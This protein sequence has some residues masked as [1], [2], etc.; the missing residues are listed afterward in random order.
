MWQR[1]VRLIERVRY[2]A[3]TL[4]LD[5]LFT[6]GMQHGNTSVT[7][8]VIP[9]VGAGHQQRRRLMIIHSSRFTSSCVLGAVFSMQ[10][11]VQGLI[12]IIPGQA[13]R[14]R[15]A[16]TPTLAVSQVGLLFL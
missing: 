5:T 8:L 14:A 1:R 2:W 13:R 9:T 4:H 16:A 7:V 3:G 12:L 6:I 11:R 15:P 10:G